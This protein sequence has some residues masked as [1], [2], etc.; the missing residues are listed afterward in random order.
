MSTSLSRSLIALLLFFLAA[1]PVNG[2]A[3]QPGTDTNAV[4]ESDSLERGFLPLGG[5]STETG[6]GLGG[7]YQSQRYTDDHF[8]LR[9]FFQIQGIG[10]TTLNFGFQTA[11]KRRS[12]NGHRFESRADLIKLNNAYFF[13]IGPST[14]FSKS[15]FDDGLNDYSRLDLLV[16]TEYGRVISRPRSDRRLEWYNGVLM[17][18][19]RHT[20]FSESR[21]GLDRPDGV[22]GGFRQAFYT[23]FMADFR[24][25]LFRPD[26]GSLYKLQLDFFPS[27]LGNQST[28]ASIESSAAAYRGFH[29]VTDLVFAARISMKQVFGKAPYYE[30]PYL[31]GEKTLRGFHFERF[32]DQGRIFTN[33][34]LRTWLF[35]LPFFNIEIG[36][37]FFADLGTVYRHPFEAGWYRHIRTTGGA[38]GVMSIYNRDFIVRGDLGISKDGW[39]IYAGLGYLF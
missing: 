11:Y 27:V 28:L 5:F 31:G 9:E 22:G 36:G 6:L 29:L 39:M 4:A 13:G 25:D 37:Q 34:E 32:R 16:Y 35:S 21:L 8:P 7:M 19:Q 12:E 14:V 1:W 30:L 2:Q 15:D 10:F 33:L 18:Y 26:S 20:N 17:G 23:G 24:S 3:I 38:G